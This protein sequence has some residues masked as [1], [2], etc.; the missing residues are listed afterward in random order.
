MYRYETTERERVIMQDEAIDIF[1]H[2]LPHGSGIDCDWK[3]T[4]H[5]RSKRI[6]MSNSYHCMDENGMYDGWSDFTVIIDWEDE[7]YYRIMFHGRESQ[8]LARKYDLRDYLTDLICECLVLSYESPKAGE[9]FGWHM[10]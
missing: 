1:N 3:I 9:S 2:V 10:D 8:R 6:H 4:F 5:N 7:E